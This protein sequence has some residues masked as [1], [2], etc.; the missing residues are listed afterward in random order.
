MVGF[1]IGQGTRIA[2]YLGHYAATRAWFSRIE[3]TRTRPSPRAR[4]AGAR[5]QGALARGALELMRQDARNV[6]R[7]IY[8]VPSD[9]APRAGAVAEIAGYWRDLPKVA[10]RRRTRTAQEPFADGEA[11]DA[12]PRYY[13]QNFHFQSGGWLS[14]ESAA[15]YDTQVEVLFC[16]LAQAMRRQGVVPVVDW[17]RANSA[18]DGAGKRL[19]DLGTGTGAMVAALRDAAPALEITGLDLSPAYLERARDHLGGDAAAWLQAPAEAIPLDDA[20]TDLVT[21]TYLFHELPK[22]I[23]I[24]VLA[25][26]R[27]ILSPGGRFVLTDSLQLGDTPLLDPVLSSFPEQFHEPYYADW[28][29]GGTEALLTEAG[30][31]VVDTRPAYLSKVFVAERA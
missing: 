16:G 27:R 19:V 23:R 14:A 11:R 18:P 1:D 9:T 25:E 21:A 26:T 20:S 31:R 29:A 30:F 8:P 15:L 6:R 28:I 13:L 17:L 4:L 22:K 2:W 10:L 7:G 12:Y 5:I 24:Q 3:P